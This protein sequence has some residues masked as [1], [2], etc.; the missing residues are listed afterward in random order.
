MR[1]ILRGHV[2][3]KLFLLSFSVAV[4]YSY[5]A[6]AQASGNYTI[7]PTVAAS[8][9]NFHTFTAAVNFL[10]SGGLGGAVIITVKAG[11][12]PYVEQVHLDNTIGTTSI[13]TLTFNCNGV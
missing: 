8:A 6:K 7:D 10:K 5:E 2:F 12:G 9:T 4:L 1:K 11:T 3:I 13:K